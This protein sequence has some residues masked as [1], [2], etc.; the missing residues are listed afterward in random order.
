M[1]LLSQEEL[2]ELIVKA[3]NGDAEARNIIF[4]SNMRLVS[5]IAGKFLGSSLEFQDL[6]QEGYI[7][8]MKAIDK[9]QPDK[10]FRFSTYATWWIRQS[11]Q[12]AISDNSRV[13]RI[14]VHIQEDL[15]RIKKASK[16]LEQELNREPSIDEIYER[17]KID[18]SWY[19]KI[20]EHEFFDEL[21]D[22]AKV[23][24]PNSS[25]VLDIE[26][27]IMED[28]D[29]PE[30]A[31]LICK[32]IVKYISNKKIVPDKETIMAKINL[33]KAK[34]KQVLEYNTNVAS[35]D[36]NINDDNDNTVGDTISSQVSV[37]EEVDKKFIEEGL[38]KAIDE[39]YGKE[40]DK[41]KSEIN[42]LE[43][44]ISYLQKKLASKNIDTSAEISVV[45]NDSSLSDLEKE[46]ILK[47]FNKNKKQSTID[48]SK[49]IDSLTKTKERKTKIIPKGELLMRRF[50]ICGYHKE[51]LEQ[52]GNRYGISRE[53]VR[54]IEKEILSGDKS[55]SRLL[56]DRIL[57]YCN[58][59][60]EDYK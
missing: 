46:S 21:V 30:D 31:E 53:R 32:K 56:K 33:S 39:V 8:L 16:S 37:E 48:V 12:R 58:L 20:V 14:P 47:Y 22:L 15:Q 55:S 7:G 36:M 41:V 25:E 18:S 60:K 3:H 51:T 23:N 44:Q 4:E 35:L 49:A 26:S 17:I 1:D 52:L 5:S 6:Q 40:L 13:I 38:K 57:E 24:D 34:I 43:I 9:Y 11:I 27:V 19:D 50:G 59:C 10:G 42:E 29:F 54:Q 45:E 28:L 2:N